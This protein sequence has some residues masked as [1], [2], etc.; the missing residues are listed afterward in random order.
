METFTEF[1]D[2]SKRLIDRNRLLTIE[3]KREV[4]GKI[5]DCIEP[6]IRLI[7]SDYENNWLI[8][9]SEMD[10]ANQYIRLAIYRLEQ[11]SKDLEGYDAGN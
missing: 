9:K 5:M 2:E 3:Q 6:V 1:C 7:G 11:I 10:R 8:Y 4:T